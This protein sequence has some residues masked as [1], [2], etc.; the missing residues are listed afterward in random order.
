[1][2]SKAKREKMAALATKCRFGCDCESSSG[3]AIA[4]FAADQVQEISRNLSCPVLVYNG[5][6]TPV[7]VTRKG[8]LMD[9]S[10]QSPVS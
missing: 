5:T 6:G 7:T 4:F 3:I 2:Q 8:Q 9:G 1:M 10:V